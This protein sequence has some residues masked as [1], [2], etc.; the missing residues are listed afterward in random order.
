MNFFPFLRLGII[1]KMEEN[2]V[3]I[4]KSKIMIFE[5]AVT[6]YRTLF[7]MTDIIV[8]VFVIVFFLGS[9]HV[10]SSLWSNVSK[11]TRLWDRS[12]KVFSKCICLCHCLCLCLYI[13]HN[14]ECAVTCYRTLKYHHFWLSDQNNIFFQFFYDTQS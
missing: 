1:K 7:I 10:P 11:V 14:K 13:G 9:G 4:R 6:C 2:V 5:C 12:L 3:L 8:I